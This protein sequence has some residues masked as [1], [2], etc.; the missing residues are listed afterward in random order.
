MKKYILFTI[1]LCLSFSLCAKRHKYTLKVC[2]GTLSVERFNINPAGVDVD[3]LTDSLNFRLYIGK[4]DNDHENF[5]YTCIG[6]S[7]FIK[8]LGIID[9]SGKFHVLE[10]R[11]YSVQKLK[12]EKGFE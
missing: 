3:Y 7:V 9:M 2:N 4:W 12:Q 6:D 1:V 11:A 10:E 8:K 5:S